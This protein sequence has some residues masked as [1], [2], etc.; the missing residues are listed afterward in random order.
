MHS[1]LPLFTK[2]LKNVYITSPEGSIVTVC[3][4]SILPLLATAAFTDAESL[5]QHMEL[6][7][8][9]VILLISLSPKISVSL[10]SLS[11]RR[12]HTIIV[13]RSFMYSS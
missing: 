8:A 6:I 2:V 4:G 11:S 9:T 5:L 10:A 12:G 3:T 1:F 7:L 13:S